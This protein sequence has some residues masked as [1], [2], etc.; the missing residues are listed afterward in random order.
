M[1]VIIRTRK[2]GQ[3]YPITPKSSFASQ[4]PNFSPTQIWQKFLQSQSPE[5]RLIL[6]QKLISNR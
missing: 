6:K 3:R 2:D 1:S 4:R 5:D